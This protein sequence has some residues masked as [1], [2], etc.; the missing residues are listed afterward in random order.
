MANKVGD[1]PDSRLPERQ[2]E[3]NERPN[4]DSDC[5]KDGPGILLAPY[6]SDQS[7]S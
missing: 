1:G 3:K 7:A 6:C 5:H 2:D 4:L